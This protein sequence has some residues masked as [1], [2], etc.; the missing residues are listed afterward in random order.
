MMVGLL[1]ISS[2]LK[3]SHNYCCSTVRTMLGVADIILNDPT[4]LHAT[5]DS[6]DGILTVSTVLPS[7]L[8]PSLC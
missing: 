4:N 2:L 1:G 3:E 5:N 7:D 8:R 6:T